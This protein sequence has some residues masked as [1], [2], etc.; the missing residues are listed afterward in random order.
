M[1]K[2][3]ISLRFMAIAT[4]VI[5]FSACAEDKEIEG[6]KGVSEMITFC[7][8]TPDEQYATR[9]V[10]S[11]SFGEKIHSMVYDK[12]DSTPYS[13]DVYKDDYHNKDLNI[14]TR[15]AVSDLT[16][17]GF[18]VM[19][20]A[21]PNN[22]TYATNACGNYFYNV[23][24][25]P[26]LPLAYYWPTTDYKLSFYAIYP[27]SPAG[28]TKPNKTQTGKPIYIYQVPN[29]NM[30]S[31]MLMSA[32]T[33]DVNGGG[34]EPIE[35]R[36]KY[37]L[38]KVTFCITNNSART[39]TYYDNELTL[40]GI[41]TKA[42]LCGGAWYDLEKGTGYIK[43]TF[44]TS[45][46]FVEPNES[47]SFTFYT[48]PCI[49]PDT[50][51]FSFGRRPL[52]GSN[53]KSEHWDVDISGIT[54]EA[55]KSYTYNI[56][57]NPGNIIIEKTSEITDW[58][59]NRLLTPLTFVA[60]ENGTFSFSKAGLSYSLDNGVTWT[61]L[62]ANANTPTVTAGNKIMWK[63]NTALTPSSSD[64]IGTFSATG[65][66]DVM[67]NIMSIYGGHDNFPTQTI[68]NKDY[69][70]NSLFNSNYR[71]RNVSNL[72][73]PATTL[74][75]G[76]YSYMFYHCWNLITA[77]NE[78][79]AT[80][81]EVSCYESMFDDCRALTNTPELPATTLADYCYL[82]MFSWCETLTTAP[83]LPATTLAEGCYWDMFYHC[84]SLTTAPE[85]PAT[86]LADNCYNSMFQDCISLTTAPELPATTLAYQCYDC[87][88]LGCINLNYIKAA[89]TTT[90]TNTYTLN[91]VKNVSSSGT[92]HKNAAATWNETGDNA[93][94]SDWTIVTYTP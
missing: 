17:N 54:W 75:E 31:N 36:F 38:A 56:I 12:E 27:K 40:R 79:P 26:N 64:G 90:P 35:L 46:S 52:V 65:D 91:W 13:V 53:E 76:C 62:A 22:Q 9:S 6:T 92:F 78:L 15:S 85:L 69:Y 63:N 45:H 58:I 87:L 73:L 57:I 20:S 44:M 94:P 50:A 30:I 37:R 5:M 4:S 28:L 77:P 7:T 55:G 86:T 47:E 43:Q 83:E 70:F 2:I 93:V 3:S 32:D 10:D 84:I 14:I 89:F 24:A 21:Y 68:I 16:S 61:A 80:T 59:D 42:K 48:I 23:T 39:G 33:T 66:F 19:A 1:K 25:K 8:K 67:G 34:Q 41:P 81:L 49:V 82:D 72:T 71:I 88:F 29:N 18:S 51:R 11:H 74:S 60:L